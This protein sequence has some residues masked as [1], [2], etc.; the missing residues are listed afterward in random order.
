[1]AEDVP[2]HKN[3]FQLNISLVNGSKLYKT[4]D[5]FSFT[6]NVLRWKFNILS[7]ALTIGVLK[8]SEVT[9]KSALTSIKKNIKK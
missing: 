8:C 5:L 7:S 3:K 2:L 4:V 6:K 9:K 1:M